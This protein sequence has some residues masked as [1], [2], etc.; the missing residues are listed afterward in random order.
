[1]F[2]LHIISLTVSVLGLVSGQLSMADEARLVAATPAC[3]KTC[4]S[5]ST[6]VSGCKDTADTALVQCYCE[7]LPFI[8]AFTQCAMA[9]CSADDYKTGAASASQACTAVGKPISI[10]ATINGTATA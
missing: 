5:Q 1:M 8:S 7:S 6:S 9:S 10:P 2:T 3:V 4:Y